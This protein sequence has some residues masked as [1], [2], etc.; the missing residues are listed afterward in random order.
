MWSLAH[1]MNYGQALG[2][3]QNTDHLYQDPHKHIP[4]SE[5]NDSS[6]ENVSDSWIW[7][8]Q[9]IPKISEISLVD[10]LSQTGS[11]SNQIRLRKQS[12]S[13]RIMSPE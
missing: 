12:S 7:W 5:E 3:G 13:S 11:K 8:F 1:S 6:P 10:L 9:D 4:H 2:M